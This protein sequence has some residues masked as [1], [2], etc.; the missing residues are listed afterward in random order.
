MT[1]QHSV[2]Y[3]HSGKSREFTGYF[4]TVGADFPASETFDTFW[5][6]TKNKKQANPGKLFSMRHN[7]TQLVF[8]NNHLN[9]LAQAGILNYQALNGTGVWAGLYPVSNHGEWTNRLGLHHLDSVHKK[10]QENVLVH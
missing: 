5:F 1:D 9:R 10:K 8:D 6:I 3:E 7:E 4:H 2:C